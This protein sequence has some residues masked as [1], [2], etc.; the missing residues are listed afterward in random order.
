MSFNKS[1]EHDEKLFRAAVLEFA[2]AGYEQ[3]SINAILKNAGMSKGQFYYHFR[4]KEALYIA[5]IEVMIA[6]K[7]D[8]LAT[9]MS[10]EDLQGDFFE[11]LE[12]QLRHGFAFARKHPEINAFSDRFL[13]EKGS[14]IYKSA[15]KRF[16]FDTDAALEQL[17]NAA[18]ERGEFR[19][20][21]PR[22][23]IRRI[24]ATLFNHAADF[25]G[26]RSVK[27]AE[28]DLAMLLE[29]MKHGLA[30]PAREK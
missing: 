21:L 23:F 28:K 13:A 12:T 29:V 22:A 8:F 1:F 6:R 24:I 2:E 7:R 20:D 3:A 26:M 27:E 15:V 4:D 5:L 9:V 14:P 17:V 16:N 30:A 19:D 11:V 25:T 18:C 10:P